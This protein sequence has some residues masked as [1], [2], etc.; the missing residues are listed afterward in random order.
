MYG[1]SINYPTTTTYSINTQKKSKPL[2]TS[3][4]THNRKNE[5]AMYRKFLILMTEG[6][7]KALEKGD[8][9]LCQR[10]NEE[11]D[12]FQECIF[13]IIEQE[14]SH[15]NKKADICTEWLTSIARGFGEALQSGKETATNLF[16]KKLKIQ[17]G[18]LTINLT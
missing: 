17:K 12:K 6:M 16:G 7:I 2:R 1:I 5:L 4:K 18:D 14:N 9:D 3:G 8:K 10:Y 13:K 15:F 11:I